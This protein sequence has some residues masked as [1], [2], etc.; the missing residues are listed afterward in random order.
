MTRSSTLL[1][2]GHPAPEVDPVTSPA[3]LLA[4]LGRLFAVH[5]IWAAGA[6]VLLVLFGIPGSYDALPGN[7][8][9]GG[10]GFRHD[11]SLLTAWWVL[12]FVWSLLL[13]LLFWLAK[14]TAR[15]AAFT[16]VV[17]GRAAAAAAAFKVMHDSAQQ[18]RI[19][20]SGGVSVVPAAADAPSYVQLNDGRYL[21]LVTCYPYGSDL[22]I[23]ATLSVSLAP[24]R[25][26]TATLRRT[27]RG[28]TP[29]AH[30]PA[31]ALLEVL[32]SVARLGVAAAG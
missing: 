24:L 3:Y 22:L 14:L 5:V 30:E 10:G 4:L 23:E 11:T 13:A 9:S 15:T 16:Y 31:R 7:V 21:G 6:V 2:T 12:M 32:H 25:W 28:G 29:A 1:S 19:P 26:L 27:F 18:R 20:V 17:D 8:T